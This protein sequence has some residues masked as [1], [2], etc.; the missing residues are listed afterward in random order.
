MALSTAQA[1]ALAALKSCV[2]ADDV[3]TL[4]QGDL[5]ALASDAAGMLGLQDQLTQLKQRCTPVN[6]CPSVL[7]AVRRV[8]FFAMPCHASLTMTASCADGRR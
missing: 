4:V 8:L 5:A 6:A 1:R 7:D 2:T 3:H